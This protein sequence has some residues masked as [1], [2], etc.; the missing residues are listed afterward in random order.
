M[1]ARWSFNLI[2]VLLTTMLVSASAGLW[3]ADD[4]ADLE[5]PGDDSVTPAIDPA[6]LKDNAILRVR[7][8]AHRTQSTN[9]LKQIMLA[10]H[11]YHDTYREF[12]GN[13]LD[14]A[15]KP[16]LS[17]RVKLLPYV[18]QN[19]LYMKFKLDEPW[20]SKNNR[21]LLEI[22]PKVYMS[23]RV[24]VKGKGYTVYQ[25][26]FGPG[27]VFDKGKA[28]VTIA[29][30]TDGLSNTLFAVETSKAVPWTKPADMPFDK[31][32]KVSMDFGKAYNNKPLGALMD[33]SVRVLDLKKIKPETLKNAIMPNDG[34]VLGADWNE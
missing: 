21:P 18:E 11:N 15:G 31:D 1:I 12:P 29:A 25:M 32:K 30:I 20:D 28:K 9:N 22:V 6:K 5:P 2:V 14:K 34:N 10:V 33:G 17:W 8:S 13:V 19:A 24:K 27:A 7:D 4:K 3:A 16:I 26:F 23:P